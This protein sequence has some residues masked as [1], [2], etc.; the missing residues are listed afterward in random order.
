M[1]DQG[2][3]I[4]EQEVRHVARLSRLAMTDQQIHHFTE[5]LAGVLDYV[6]KLNELDVEGVEP[7]AH[8]L[9]MTNVMRDDVNQPGLSVETALANAPERSFPYFK[10]PRILG[11]GSEA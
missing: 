2:K 4:T 8:A 9:E 10:A 7:M 1:T 5:Q 6:A 3:R 11:E